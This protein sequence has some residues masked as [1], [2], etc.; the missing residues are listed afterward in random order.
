MRDIKN[1]H[2][3]EQTDSDRRSVLKSAIGVAFTGMLVSLGVP[4]ISYVEL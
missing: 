3:N 4:N 2:F 1:Y